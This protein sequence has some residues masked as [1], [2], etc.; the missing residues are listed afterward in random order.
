ML[1]AYLKDI[2]GDKYDQYFFQKG[3]SYSQ[4]LKEEGILIFNSFRY[5]KKFYNKEIKKH[6]TFVML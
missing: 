4:I 6:L 2:L 3:S 5:F 1:P